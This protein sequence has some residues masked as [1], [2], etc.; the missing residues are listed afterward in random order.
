VSPAAHVTA[1]PAVSV[2]VPTFNRLQFLPAAITSLRE[3]SETDWQLIIADDGS[4]DATR[5]YLRTLEAPPRVTILWLAH[6]GRPGIARNAALRVARGEFI[7]FLDS[8]DLWLPHKLARQL[9]SLR[10]QPQRHWGYTAFELIDASGRR[11]RRGA[12]ATPGG[13]ILETL[14]TERTVIALPSVVVRRA[15]LERL[16]G[17]DERL[18]MCEDDELWLRLA[19]ASEVDAL[20]EPLTLVRRHGQHGGN[21]RT[22]WRDRRTVFER[23]L[24]RNPPPR[25]RALLRGLRAQMS[26]GL[27][28]SEARSG[29]RHAAFLTL[30]RSAPYS[31]RYPLWWHGALHCLWQLLAPAALRSRLRS[32]RQRRLEA[33]P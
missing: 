3:Q 5:A 9:A 14:L 11:R 15:L 17:F 33:R 10:R 22:A 16:G 21:D 26:A 7:A 12:A 29:L 32:L 31:W 8:D 4:D 13:W 1:S 24:E 27:A 25:V 23:A 6:S 2:I 30:L 20:A 18:T 19:A 28:R